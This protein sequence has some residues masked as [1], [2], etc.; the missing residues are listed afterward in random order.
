MGQRDIIPA[1]LLMG[2]RQIGQLQEPMQLCLDL[3][4]FGF[5]VGQRRVEVAN[6]FGFSGAEMFV[7]RAAGEFFETQSASSAGTPDTEG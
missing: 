7:G 4:R 6:R 5:G 2:R 3:A 1:R